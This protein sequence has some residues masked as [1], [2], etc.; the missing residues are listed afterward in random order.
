MELV[1]NTRLL[2]DTAGSTNE[3]QMLTFKAVYLF[4]RDGQKV[5]PTKKAVSKQGFHSMS[6]IPQ[7]DLTS[8]WS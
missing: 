1:G 8:S 3:V 2:S 4:I 6:V 5:K 7:H